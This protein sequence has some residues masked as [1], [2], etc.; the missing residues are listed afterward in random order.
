MHGFIVV[1]KPAGMTSHDV[2]ARVRR[3]L[4]MKKVG[5]TGT[6]DPFATG[7]LPVALGEG[8]KAIPFL[9]EGVKEYR[10]VMML[11]VATDTEDVDG[12]VISEHPLDGIDEAAIRTV[13]ATFTGTISQIPPMFSALK[14]NGVPL[15]KLARKGEEVEREP[16]QVTIYS[17]VLDN[18][19]LPLVAFTVR[20]SRG[21]YVR[22]LARD[23]GEHLGCGAHLTELRRTRSGPFTLEQ[24]RTLEQLADEAAAGPEQARIITLNEALAHL[25]H[26]E[27]TADG[28]R[29]VRNGVSPVADDLEAPHQQHAPGQRLVLVRGRAVVAVAEEQAGNLLIVRGFR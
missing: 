9:D 8:T 10:A 5:H 17:L 22:S 18:I 2:V 11:G 15:Y 19:N 13:P 7:V 29:R 23:M 28:E 3:I 16:R 24:A 6:L 1:D 25:P 27:L 20:C 26:L 21:A 14:R 12:K 4:K